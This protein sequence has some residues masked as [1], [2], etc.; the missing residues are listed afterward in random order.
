MI[1]D[2]AKNERHGRR[3]MAPD[4][5]WREAGT[6][7]WLLAFLL[8][9]ST[10]FA[11]PDAEGDEDFQPGLVAEYV[12]QS[13]R[14]R[15]R[16]I[17]ADIQFCWGQDSPDSRL[18]AGPFEAIWTGR[19]LIQAP[20]TYRFSLYLNGSGEVRLND[21]MAV[22]GHSSPAGWI[23][24]EPRQLSGEQAL[25]VRFAKDGNK[26]DGSKAECK[27]YWSS[28]SFGLEPIPPHLL[29]HDD[30]HPELAVL[31]RGAAQFAAHRCNRCHTREH[32]VAAPAAPALTHLNFGTDPAW[33]TN[34]LL[35]PR[36]HNSQS[37]MPQFGFTRQE[38]ESITA[39]LISVGTSPQAE[40][41]AKGAKDYGRKGEVLFRSLGCLACHPRGEAGSAAAAEPGGTWS[42]GDLTQIHR[43]RT[44]DWLAL[45]LTHPERLS[46]DHR[47]PVFALEPAEV[48]QLTAY[49]VGSNPKLLAA[50]AG[51]SARPGDAVVAQGKQLVTAARCAACHKIPG[52]PAPAAPL[53]TLAATPRDPAQSCLQDQPDRRTWRPAYAGID[54]QAVETYLQ[55]RVGPLSPESRFEQ[56]RRLLAWN[57]C[58][59]CHPRHGSQG[60][61]PT[62]AAMASPRAP[63]SSATGSAT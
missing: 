8:A 50:A 14:Q 10:A 30:P 28:D 3:A 4:F 12:Q 56:G 45:W 51:D 2:A 58:L 18:G 57:N 23:T 27:L 43:K 44:A 9:S 24:G 38:A 5:S 32:E 35:D 6:G 55:S 48:A 42:G 31:E 54:R 40:P 39:Y 17:D 22:S 53:P 15:V 29:F 49:L 60:I 47:M 16:R 33:L 20:G 61:G 59:A 62:A 36:Q 19:L 37:R 34:W 46:E 25:T 1:T 26:A 7:G 11:Q 41:L 52:V 63:V 21:A 13:G